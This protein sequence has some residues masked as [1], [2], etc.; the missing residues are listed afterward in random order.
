MVH[1]IVNV[2]TK[3]ADDLLSVLE[4]AVKAVKTARMDAKAAAAQLRAKPQAASAGTP[5]AAAKSSSNPKE[6]GSASTNQSQLEGSLKEAVVSPA[7]VPQ[8]NFALPA[9]ANTSSF[10]KQGSNDSAAEPVTTPPTEKVAQFPSAP[11]QSQT[12]PSSESA[13]AQ[14]AAKTRSYAAALR[15]AKASPEKLTKEA[16]S[17]PSHKDPSQ[18]ATTT[19]SPSKALRPSTPTPQATETEPSVQV[20]GGDAA[21]ESAE[22]VQRRRHEEEAKSRADKERQEQEKEKEKERERLEKEKKAKE[23]EE[24][25]ALA[26]KQKLEKQRAEE[27]RRKAEVE[28]VRAER[29]ER[30]ERERLEKEAHE[31]AAQEAAAQRS[32]EE[33]KAGAKLSKAITKV[34]QQGVLY[35]ETYKETAP[36]THK[37][38]NKSKMRG[39]L[40]R[41]NNSDPRAALRE[42]LSLCQGSGADHDGPFPQLET[43]FLRFNDGFEVLVKKS[44]DALTIRDLGLFRLATDA[45]RRLLTDPSLGDA[46]VDFFL[47]S[48][49]WS[50]VVQGIFDEIHLLHKLVGNT[51]TSG[52]KTA[53]PNAA[54]GSGGAS[55]S[56]TGIRTTF[57]VSM[58]VSILQTCLPRLL[59]TT[60][61]ALIPV[62]ESFVDLLSMA[63]FFE[64]VIDFAASITKMAETPSLLAELSLFA[65]LLPVVARRKSTVDEKRSWTANV[66]EVMFH[67]L[68]TLIAPGGQPLK[69][70]ELSN[71]AASTCFVAL[72]ILNTIARNDIPTLQQL[73]SDGLDPATVASKEVPL[74]PAADTV[75]SIAQGFMCYLAT[76][77]GAFAP[78]SSFTIPAAVKGV[79]P[80]FRDGTRFGLTEPIPIAPPL[81][82][83]DTPEALPK[84]VEKKQDKTYLGAALHELLLF[85]GYASVLNPAFQQLMNRK[86]ATQKTLL[87]M[88]V[89]AVDARYF[90]LGKQILFPTLIAVAL[91]CEENKAALLNEMN[92]KD[93]AA[94]LDEE[95]AAAKAARKECPEEELTPPRQQASQIAEKQPG[96]G[97]GAAAGATAGLAAKLEGRASASGCGGGTTASN[98]SW[99]EMM[100]EEDEGLAWEDP[101]SQLSASSPAPSWA[102]TD[103]TPTDPAAASGTGAPTNAQLTALTVPGGEGDLHAPREHKRIEKLHAITHT[104]LQQGIPPYLLYFRLSRRIPVEYWMSAREFFAK[105]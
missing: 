66:V 84:V 46:N 56:T 11:V 55:S 94:F 91:H 103:T 8:P 24:A 74:P 20:E 13:T 2:N 17:K 100:E 102:K 23:R 60:V 54:A 10:D 38:L 78:V 101:L 96:S 21:V 5:S 104:P 71:T 99:A 98:K 50:G 47:C 3:D 63:G 35:L 83:G 61:K 52:S 32:E 92:V 80:S 87:E 33:V 51:A 53:Q 82:L 40:Q 85:L 89:V 95:L 90:A 42:M 27:E 81:V 86:G 28:R 26:K 19:G 1:H 45:L 36:R 41:L 57:G 14:S 31:K 43:E 44:L 64:H 16:P 72:R 7:S 59:D 97:S 22:A 67:V 88:L 93:I 34:Q 77:A 65:S 49:C 29:E 48:G 39:V 75:F 73:I 30:K 58:L 9:S 18:G 25:E 15:G 6:T 70:K 68:K 12:A 79:S 76:H 37:D 4:D 62:R 69:D 105:D